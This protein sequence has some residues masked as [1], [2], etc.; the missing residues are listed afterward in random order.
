MK[1]YIKGFSLQL[2][3]NLLAH[4]IRILIAYLIIKYAPEPEYP[5]SF[6][7]DSGWQIIS[8][9]SII[10]YN[11]ISLI[12]A[13]IKHRKKDIRVFKGFVIASILSIIYAVK[14]CGL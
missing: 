6:S 9:F 7:K 12:V 14:F 8:L 10:G 4:A 5:T 13:F 2:C 1:K 11:I 3:I